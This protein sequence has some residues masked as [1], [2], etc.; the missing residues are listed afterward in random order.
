MKL[1]WSHIIRWNGEISRAPFLLWAGLLLVVKCNFDRLLLRL[2]FDRDWSVASYFFRPLPWIDGLSPARNPSEFALLLALS[3]PFLWAGLALC[4]QRLRSAQLPPWLAV[5]FVVPVVKWFLFVALAF[6]PGR[7]KSEAE[8]IAPD[9]R[10]PVASWMPASVFGSAALAVGLTVLPALAVTALATQVLREYG[11][12]LFAGLPFCMGFLAA[13]IHGGR[14]RRSLAQSQWVAFV[15]VALAGAALLALAFEGIICLLMAAPL[16]FALAAVGAL[17]GHAVQSGRR[18]GASAKL[19]GVPLL[20]MPLML[21]TDSLRTGPLPLLKVVTAVE[22]EAPVERVWPHVVEFSDL[23]PPTEPL[24]RLGIA[25]P[26]HAELHGHGAGA[27]RHCVF[28]TGPFVEP[29]EVWD[30]PRLLKFSVTQNPA[31][32]QEWTPYREVHPPHLN[33]FLVSRQGQ[34]RLTALANGRTRLEGTT[35]YHHSMWPAAYW[36]LWSDQIIHRIHRR[37]LNHVKNL[38]EERER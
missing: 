37:V 31:P 20:A 4:F 15:A 26:I 6:V 32:M 1:K 3:L 35:W 16:A 33:G 17:A 34:F 21:G 14:E 11:W 22:V 9:E 10:R 29:I 7:G 19:F 18:R 36:R 25:Y 30:E 5:L 2:V 28:S 23:P 27:V 12:G 8:D 24:F 38:S 13:I